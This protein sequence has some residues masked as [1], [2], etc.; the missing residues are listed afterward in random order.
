MVGLAFSTESSS[1]VEHRFSDFGV[2]EEAIPSR[3]QRRLLVSPKSSVK[4]ELG[5]WLGSLQMADTEK[6]SGNPLG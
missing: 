2:L 3:L 5:T 1:W 4:D 6:V